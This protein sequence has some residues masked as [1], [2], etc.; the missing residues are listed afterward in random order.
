[1]DTF[2]TTSDTGKGKGGPMIAKKIHDAKPGK[3]AHGGKYGR[4][5][6]VARRKSTEHIDSLLKEL[7]V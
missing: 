2:G 7:T 3:G 1:M 6:V 4:E 5:A